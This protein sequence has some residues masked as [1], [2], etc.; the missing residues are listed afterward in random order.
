MALTLLL[1]IVF[2][3]AGA[4]AVLRGAGTLRHRF[5]IPAFLVGFILIGFGTSLPETALAIGATTMRFEG[6]AL[7]LLLGSTIVNLALILGLSALVKPLA[8]SRKAIGRD[9][10]AT[11]IAALYLLISAV[12]DPSGWI[13]PVFGLVLFSVYV[14]TTL[15]RQRELAGTGVMAQKANY[16]RTGPAKTLFAV[17]LLL[18]GLGG[19]IFGC[20]KLIEGS[21]G[22]AADQG[23]STAIIG[24]A[25]V[26]LIT[27]I[28]EAVVSL[29]SSYKGQCDVA[30]ANLLGSSIFN[31]LVVL[32]ICML[33]MPSGVSFFAGDWAMHALAA[34]LIS[35]IAAGAIISGRAV[36]RLEGG[37]LVAIY[38]A[39]MAAALS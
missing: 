2:I 17:I 39:Y 1:G 13:W 26:A 25:I 12:A 7:G 23:V 10:L 14:V 31:L 33:L 5:K 11:V 8:L 27:S 37:I 9:G 6:L 16:I 34:A 28:P 15:L 36:S 32:P 18:A 21:V 3:V 4:E 30:V 22:Y 35:L 20:A 38:V 29:H 19:I 24:L